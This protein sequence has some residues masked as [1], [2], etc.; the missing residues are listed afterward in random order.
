MAASGAID[1]TKAGKYPVILSDALLGKPSKETYTGVRYNHRPALSSDAAP[2]TARL[3]QSAKDSSYN[4]GFDDNG[5]KYQYN[6]MRVTEDGKYVL[7]FDPA[8]KAFILHRVDSMFHMNL[9]KTPTDGNIESL[10]KQFPHLEVKSPSSSSNSKQQKGKAADKIEKPGPA[11]AAAT[12]GKGKDTNAKDTPKSKSKVEKSKPE[13][14]KPEKSKSMGLTLPTI[15]KSTPPPPPPATAA[16]QKNS[17]SKRRPQSPVDSEEEDDGG[18]ILEYPGGP[19]P[20]VGFQPPSSFNNFSPAFPTQRRFSEYARNGGQEED[21][22]DADAEFEDVDVDAEEVDEGFKLPSPVNHHK[23][24]DSSLPAADLR[25]EFE[26][27]TDADAEGDDDI[28]MDMNPAD[29]NPV[30]QD[31]LAAELE[32]AFANVENHDDSEVSE[33][34]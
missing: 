31:D 27:E 20:V 18:L 12:K 32:A 25:F 28:D 30:G 9:T 34:E 2:A 1:P 17:S 8:R 5:D 24:V 6:G 3:K 29:P 7:I 22:E 14:S 26:D 11:K 4:L 23:T 10:R 21:D 19:P 16:A 33:E 13:K 15:S